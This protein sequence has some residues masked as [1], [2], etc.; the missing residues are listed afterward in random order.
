MLFLQSR[1]RVAFALMLVSAIAGVCVG[2]GVGWHTAPERFEPSSRMIFD[3]DENAVGQVAMVSHSGNAKPP[4]FNMYRSKLTA[5]D[6][7]HYEKWFSDSAFA[8]TPLLTTAHFLAV[9]NLMKHWETAQDVPTIALSGRLRRY[10]LG[11]KRASFLYVAFPRRE[12]GMKLIFVAKLANGQVVM[13]EQGFPEEEKAE[14][15]PMVMYHATTV[16]MKD[17][18]TNA[19]RTAYGRYV[20]I[21]RKRMAGVADDCIV[22]P[23]TQELVMGLRMPNGA[24]SN[25]VSVELEMIDEKELDK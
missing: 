5:Q 21:D 1:T 20:E 2:V 24:F 17:L 8:G 15:A 19:E 6:V 11:M 18:L 22:A 9:A 14:W 12:E 16:E 4:V 13:L 10:K 7:E 23:R 3:T 25:F